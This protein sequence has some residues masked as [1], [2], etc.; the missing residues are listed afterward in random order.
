MITNQ[1][2][3]YIGIVNVRFNWHIFTKCGWFGAV[4]SPMKR[5]PKCRQVIR[6]APPM[7]PDQDQHGHRSMVSTCLPPL[8]KQLDWV[9]LRF[10]CSDQ[11]KCVS[12]GTEATIDDCAPNP[13]QNG[14]TCTDGV[15]EYICSCATGWIGPQCSSKFDI[16]VYLFNH[17]KGNRC[18]FLFYDK[19]T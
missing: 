15:N 6:D 8:V 10:V 4:E 12:V 11:I 3:S 13:C 1:K 9:K 19:G 5:A 14:G 17:R 2:I 7:A 16:M 18:Q